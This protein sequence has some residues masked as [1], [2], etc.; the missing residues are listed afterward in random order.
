VNANR[1]A[2]LLNIAAVA[3]ARQ[4]YGTAVAFCG[5]AL[6]LEP[7][8]TK[9]LLRRAKAHTRRHELQVSTPALPAVCHRDSWIEIETVA[10]TYKL[11]NTKA[12]L[13]HAK[14]HMR[15][16]AAASGSCG[17]PDMVHAGLSAAGVT[18]NSFWVAVQR[19]PWCTARQAADDARV[20]LPHSGSQYQPNPVDRLGCN[21]S[22]GMLSV[23]RCRARSRT[24][25]RFWRSSAA[26]CGPQHDS[27]VII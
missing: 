11:R 23:F 25:G 15:R 9:A 2:V 10:V 22:G 4:Q 26:A 17:F 14:A 24:W 20:A 21:V 19:R 5:R 16:Q 6:A 12:L 18:F 8:N 13:R 7:R 3:M 1:V 27:F